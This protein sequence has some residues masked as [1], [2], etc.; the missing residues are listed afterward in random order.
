MGDSL[1]RVLV[2][3]DEAPV[4][5]VLSECLTAQGYTVGE[6]AIGGGSPTPYSERRAP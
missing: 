5:E 1:G 4:R 3:D 6:A 2:V